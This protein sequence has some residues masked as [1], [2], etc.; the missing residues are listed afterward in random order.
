MALGDKSPT[1]K[2][3]ALSAYYLSNYSTLHI[4]LEESSGMSTGYSATT[5]ALLDEATGSGLV[6]GAATLSLVTTSTTNDTCR[7]YYLF[8][9]ATSATIHG[10]V[11]CST[12]STA[13]Y[14]MYSWYCYAASVPI[15]SGDTLACTNDHQY[16]LGT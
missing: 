10:H 12:A 9:A 16:K 11:V 14:D 6:R 13:S 8:T 2:L 1:A 7:A 4:A 3:Y 15:E 5:N